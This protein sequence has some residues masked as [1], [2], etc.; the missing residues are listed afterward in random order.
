MDLLIVLAIVALIAG[1][2][3]YLLCKSNMNVPANAEVTVPDD[4]AETYVE[5]YS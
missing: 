1:G 2:V 4:E 3:Y 5:K